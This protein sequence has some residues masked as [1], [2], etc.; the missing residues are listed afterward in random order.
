M[1]VSLYVH[2]SAKRGVPIYRN[3]LK[4]KEHYQNPQVC[5]SSI[6]QLSYSTLAILKKMTENV[7][8]QDTSTYGQSNYGDN[9]LENV[10][11]LLSPCKV[12]FS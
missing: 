3:G 9:F 7:Q 4:E 1:P 2:K 12:I 6:W 5:R 10:V 8:R 11:S